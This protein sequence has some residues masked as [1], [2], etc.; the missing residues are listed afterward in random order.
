MDEIERGTTDHDWDQLRP[1]LDDAVNRLNDCDRDAILLRFFEGQPF[2]QIGAQLR[3]TENSARMRVERALDK[4][5]HTMARR[6][7]ASTAA[8][9]GTALSNAATLPAVPVGLA[10]SA[11]N[12]ALASTA[13][14]AAAGP[15]TIFGIMGASKLTLSVAGIISIVALGV[16]IYEA[17]AHRET[18]LALSSAIEQ[19]AELQVRV[20]EAEVRAIAAQESSANNAAKLTALEGQ[21]AKMAQERLGG[22]PPALPVENKTPQA[23]RS[24]ASAAERQ[25]LHMR[26]D[27]F[28][29]RFGLT[30]AQMDRFVELKLAIYEAQDDLQA[31]VAQNGL[32]G[33]SASVEALRR[34]LTKP[35]WDEIRELL[36]SEGYS[37]YG[38]YELISAIRP[39]ITGLFQSSGISISDEA[40]DQIARLVHKHRRLYRAKPTDISSQSQIDWAGVAQDAETILTPSQIEVLRARAAALTR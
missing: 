25:K 13:A 6:G 5:R 26:Y 9:L 29:A 38:D 21:A 4:L 20:R 30:S 34:E 33:D 1:L 24:I 37:A 31:S 11:T 36:G 15:S 18:K 3:I 16:A 39:T 14:L 12:G 27:P 8:A 17:L 40:K 2:A 28:L 10:A 19:R 22:P 23:P 7:I 32:P 35:M